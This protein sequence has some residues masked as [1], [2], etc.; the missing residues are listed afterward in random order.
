MSVW[1]A[2]LALSFSRSYNNQSKGGFFWLWHPYIETARLSLKF[3]TKP[4]VVHL[5]FEFIR[6][7]LESTVTSLQQILRNL[8]CRMAYVSVAIQ[9]TRRK[10]GLSSKF[11]KIIQYVFFTSCR[12]FIVDSAFFNPISIKF[13]ADF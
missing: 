2:P 4:L 5:K 3:L 7:Q 10:L 8:H 9:K 13:S 6:L 12:S 11:V 1:Q